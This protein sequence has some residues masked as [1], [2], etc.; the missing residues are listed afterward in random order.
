MSLIN[1]TA[2]PSGAG[3]EIE[4][5]LRFEDG[6]SAY[7]SRTPSSAGNRK[8]WTMSLWFKRGNLTNDQTIFQAGTTGGNRANIYLANNT[9]QFLDTTSTDVLFTSS[10]LLRDVSSW[11]H[12]VVQFDTTQGTASDR[13]KMAQG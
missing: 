4:Q 2:I 5:S 6:S 12:L 13:L 11:Y 7:L 9:I 10:Q 8:T 1:S 3:Y